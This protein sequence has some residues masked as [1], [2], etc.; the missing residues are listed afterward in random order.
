MKIAHI[1]SRGIP[2]QYSGVEK[3]IEETSVRLAKEGFQ[4]S[5][6]CHSRR[7]GHSEYKSIKLI[8]LPTINT[9]HLATLAHSFLS[10]IHAIFTDAKIIHYHCLGPSVFS[11]IPRLFGKKTIVTVHALDW[12]RAKWNPIAQFLLRLCEIPAIYFP[13]KT[14]VVSKYLQDYFKNKYNKD[15]IH[16]PHGI[17]LPIRYPLNPIRYNNY[18]LF[19]GRIVPEKGLHYLIS[20]F[21]RI[22][23]DKE[24]WIAGSPSFTDSY[25]IKLKEMAGSN[26]KFLGAVYRE[27][28]QE[29][30]KN[31]YMFILPSETEGSPFALLEAM[32]HGK[33]C[34]VSDIPECLEGVSG[35]VAGFKNKDELDLKYKLGNLL[36]NPDLVSA[37][38][39][40][41]RQRISETRSW[42]KI[43]PVWK[44]TYAK[45]L[46]K[47]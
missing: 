19:V 11:F 2:A 33:C 3:L 26:I 45:L 37:L 28:L 7:F 10:T 14:I 36:K 30:Y 29:L 32:S 43:I 25:F 16:V 42:S 17:D 5:V 31:C 9:K 24:L 8:N 21:N 23:T 47:R 18:L 22:K 46:K 1:G 41:A 6:Y 13:N 4:I 40:K 12:K 38:G 44:Q 15:T 35:A 34:L 27:D 39:E 20:A